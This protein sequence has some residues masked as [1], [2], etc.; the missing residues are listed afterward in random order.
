MLRLQPERI[1][2]MTDFYEEILFAEREATEA[3]WQ[4][5]RAFLREM[6]RIRRKRKPE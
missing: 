4:E 3:E 6:N 1:D 2:G 5:S